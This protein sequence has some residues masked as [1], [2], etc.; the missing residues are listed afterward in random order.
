MNLGTELT[1]YLAQGIDLQHRRLERVRYLT[2]GEPY[3]KQFEEIVKWKQD[4]RD[5]NL[6][7]ETVFPANWGTVYETADRWEIEA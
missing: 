3:Q 4:R 5:G 7:S 2:N 1:R 6:R